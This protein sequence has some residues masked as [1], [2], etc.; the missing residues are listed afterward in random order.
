MKQ[1]DKKSELFIANNSYQT[2]TLEQELQTF[3]LEGRP[4]EVTKIEVGI[5][6]PESGVLLE[7]GY[8]KEEEALRIKKLKQ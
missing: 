1:Q 7:W 5:F 2:R 4:V 8:T 6:I 3:E